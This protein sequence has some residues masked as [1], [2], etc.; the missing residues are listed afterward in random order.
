MN[1]KD[2]VRLNLLA[3]RIEAL[4]CEILAYIVVPETELVT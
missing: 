4:W 2:S 1:G 3:K